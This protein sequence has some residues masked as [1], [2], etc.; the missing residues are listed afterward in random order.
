MAGRQEIRERPGRAVPGAEIV[1]LL[2]TDLV[3]STELFQRLG[4]DAAAQVPRIHFR[5]LR[6]AVAARGGHEV[7]NLGDGL[8]VVFSSAMDAVG[9]AV[10]IQ[11][12]VRAYNQRREGPSSTFGW[13]ST[14]A[15]RFAMKA[16]LAPSRPRRQQPVAPAPSAGGD[17]R[18]GS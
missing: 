13:A 15:S 12:A 9:S 5:L 11:E 6:D 16:A 4:D 10:A 17:P 2:F 3:G 14:S 8:M 1:I 18:L 7:K